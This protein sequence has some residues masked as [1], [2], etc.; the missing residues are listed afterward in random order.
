MFT[1]EQKPQRK[2]SVGIALCRRQAITRVPQIL[3]IKSRITYNF[4]AFVFGKYKPWDSEKLQYRFNNTTVNE[5]LLIWSCD[6]NKLWYHIWLKI[7]SSDQSDSFYIFYINCRSKFERLISKD[8]GRKL[9]SLICKAGSVELGWEIPKGRQE[10]DES[11]IDC[12]M[13]EVAEETG[14]LANEYHILHNIKPICMSH[15][16]ENTIYV[17]KYFVG[18]TDK[19]THDPILN[20]NNP[21]QIS[22]VSDLRWIGL[23]EANTLVAQNKKL[24]T[25]VRLALKLFKKN[26]KIE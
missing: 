6:F 19:I 26:V 10:I 25:Q 23:K 2:T 17:C 13:R 14:I 24:G 8:G 16:D 22:E 4:S 12:A 18:W 9:R 11:E 5:K 21:S 7:P 20:F 15:E 3:L 1:K